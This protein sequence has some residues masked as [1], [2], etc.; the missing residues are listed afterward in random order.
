MEFNLS[1]LTP[2]GLK[3]LA[4]YGIKDTNGDGKIDKNEFKPYE[5]LTAQI[6]NILKNYSNINLSGQQSSTS[7]QELQSE[8]VFNTKFSFPP[9]QEEIDAQDKKFSKETLPVI[10]DITRKASQFPPLSEMSMEQKIEEYKQLDVEYKL[11]GKSNLSITQDG[12]KIT[13]K[14]K[15]LEPFTLSKDEFDQTISRSRQDSDETN[16]DQ[17]GIIGSF[18]QGGI[19]DC[20][21]LAALSNLSESTKGKQIAKD[22]IKDNGNGT[23]TVK[24][25]GADVPV[26]VTEDEV[27]KGTIVL[28]GKGEPLSP[29]DKDALIID[30]E[31]YNQDGTITV[32]FKNGKPP[33]T[34]PA[35][36]EAELDKYFRE[37]PISTGDKDVRILELAAEKYIEKHPEQFNNYKSIEGNYVENAWRL[38]TGK[39]GVSF[40]YN[41]IWQRLASSEDAN[42]PPVSNP[43]EEA[44]AKF[45]NILSNTD[46]SRL[47]CSLP[48]MRGISAA[49]KEK[50]SV[51]NLPGDRTLYRQHVYN[52]S[53]TKTVDGTLYITL[54]NPMNTQEPVVITYDEFNLYGFRLDVLDKP[55]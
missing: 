29:N 14:Y 7:P 33:V 11:T 1:S 28:N 8:S 42:K 46:P 37:R 23:Y 49:D 38:L 16:Y 5:N 34:V 51:M 19:G 40:S 53:G 45:K 52:I 9:S 21:F 25:K 26:E 41:E 35:G 17:D 36:K 22:T 27:K 18:E 4:K 55:K 24:F 15:D 10:K 12:D 50:Y 3:E 32:T 20:W 48:E 31:Q 30:K 47:T 2:D 54:V 39:S 6:Q 13:I 43:F 44:D